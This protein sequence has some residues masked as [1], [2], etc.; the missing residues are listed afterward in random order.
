MIE[1]K[2]TKFILVRHGET[3]WNLCK[4]QQGHLDSPLTKT[5]IEQAQLL[6]KRLREEKID[7]LYSSDL[8]RAVRTAEIIGG[9]VDLPVHPDNRLRERN[10]GSM[11]G[12]TL[13]DYRSRWPGQESFVDAT[14]LDYAPPGGESQ[15]QFCNRCIEVCVDLSAR[16]PGNSILL[17]AHGG[18]LKC[19]FYHILGIELTQPRRFSMFNAAINSF[20][21]SPDG[22]RLITWGDTC[23]LNGT[24]VLDEI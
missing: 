17:V 1:T 3:E 18:V 21:V 2:E 4:K 14:D 22:W 7:A 16:H 12:M 11:Q 10:F 6:A 19:I 8:G 9:E 24:A 20:S 13:Q 5:G 23:H 15:R